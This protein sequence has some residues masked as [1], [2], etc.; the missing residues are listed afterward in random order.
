M[1]AKSDAFELF[2]LKLDPSEAIN[3]ADYR[4]EKVAELDR[5]IKEH[6]KETGALLP[7]ANKNFKGNPM[8][9]RT[10]PKKAPNRPQR[11][12]LAENEI[13][14][15][16]AGTRRV[17]LLDEKNQSRKTH[18]LVLEG[19]EWVTVDNR[20]DGCV[21]LKWDAPPEGATARI[22]FGWKGGATCMEINDWT[23]PPC[24]LN[25]SRK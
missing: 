22:L 21:E 5:L 14:A 15:Q 11:L 4:P 20:S 2:N 10:N 3:L 8:R 6:L 1:N 16:E 12:R 24:E 17:Q 7:I 18:A 25:L 13:L 19:T 9:S 23:I